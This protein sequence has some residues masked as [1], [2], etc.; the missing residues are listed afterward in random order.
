MD[1]LYCDGTE[2]ALGDCRFD[3]WGESD[4]APEEA[5]GVVCE[6]N[7]TNDELQ[8]L[9]LEEKPKKLKKVIKESYGEEKF[10]VRLEGGRQH[11]EGR[12]E[13]RFIVLLIYIFIKY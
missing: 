2:K 5:A 12:V 1:N 3:G 9:R 6:N 7:E 13:V 11:Y 8:E 10:E 4:C